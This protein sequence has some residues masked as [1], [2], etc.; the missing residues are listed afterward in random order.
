[1][2]T[3]NYALSSVSP[4]KPF[5]ASLTLDEAIDPFDIVAVSPVK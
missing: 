1:M 3:V 2:L 5:C 4:E